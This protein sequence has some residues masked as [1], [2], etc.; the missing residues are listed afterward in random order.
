MYSWRLATIA[1]STSFAFISPFVFFLKKGI[2]VNCVSYLF[3]LLFIGKTS[4]I[5]STFSSLSSSS[6]ESFSLNF[7]SFMA[8]FSSSI[9]FLFLF[10]F[11]DSSTSFLILSAS[12]GFSLWV[13]LFS[14]VEIVSTLVEIV[15]PLFLLVEKTFSWEN[16]TVFFY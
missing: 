1:F 4:S 8:S 7:N 5:L 10:F 11:F 2:G 3:S 9:L 15:S 12:N 13:L 16:L 14:S 6:S